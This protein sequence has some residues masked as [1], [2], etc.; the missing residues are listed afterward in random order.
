M[1][2]YLCSII[3]SYMDQKA[4][5]ANQY[6][7]LDIRIDFLHLLFCDIE[8][9]HDIWCFCFFATLVILATYNFY[10]VLQP[11]ITCSLATCNPICIKYEFLYHIINF[12]V[13]RHFFWQIGMHFNVYDTTFTIDLLPILNCHNVSFIHKISNFNSHP[14]VHE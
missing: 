12:S 10:A 6:I 1:I 8:L 3:L 2:N 13:N 14:K 11:M 9:S 7:E 4:I 5:S